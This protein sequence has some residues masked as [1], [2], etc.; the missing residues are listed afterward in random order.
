M[1]YYEVKTTGHIVSEYD[2]K[3]AYEICTGHAFNFNGN[4]SHYRR[5][6]NLCPVRR[7]PE[8]EITVE[9]L[10]RGGAL[11]GAVKLYREKNSCSL[12]EARDAC[13]KIRDDM[14]HI[15]N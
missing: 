7:I 1:I 4:V 13:N 14:D 6:A 10:I 2:L 12:L 8:N 5:W 15:N 11:V 3:R 9:R